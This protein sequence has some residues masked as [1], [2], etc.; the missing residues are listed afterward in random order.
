MMLLLSFIDIVVVM[1]VD[2]IIW[3][4]IIRIESIFELEVYDLKD[5]DVI[6]INDF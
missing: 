5:K 2:V 6:Y 1:D 3:N 4:N